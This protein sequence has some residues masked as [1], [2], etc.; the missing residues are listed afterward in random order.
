LSAAYY[1]QA[2][3][4]LLDGARSRALGSDLDLLILAFQHGLAAAP[5]PLM[6]DP[7]QYITQEAYVDFSR[8][9]GPIFSALDLFLSS[10]CRLQP[11]SGFRR[12]TIAEFQP[13]AR[14]PAPP[15]KSAAS[16]PAPAATARRP[17][18]LRTLLPA[19]ASG[20]GSGAGSASATGL[21]VGDICPKCGA[22]VR[23]RPLLTGTFIGCLC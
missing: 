8:P 19:S 9:L 23:E 21:K 13:G 1:A 22:E 7:G 20:T 6:T 4:F 14:R 3:V 12:V 11:Q 17:L 15:L 16:L 10:Q 18:R 5:D 2:G